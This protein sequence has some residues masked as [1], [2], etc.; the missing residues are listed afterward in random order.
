MTCFPQHCWHQPCCCRLCVC[1]EV[2]SE[3]PYSWRR[4]R[5]RHV[6]L[7][8]GTQLPPHT[9]PLART[10]AQ[11]VRSPTGSPETALRDAVP[12]CSPSTA[13][14]VC[15]CAPPLPAVSRRK[16]LALAFK[17]EGEQ[18]LSSPGSSPSVGCESPGVVPS[19]AHRG[20]MAREGEEA[21]PAVP[22]TASLAQRILKRLGVKPSAC[23]GS[24]TF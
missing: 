20:L 7:A 3:M 9:R 24:G 16:L 8:E 22:V 5:R 4:R 14:A 21:A 11:R 6:N 18:P 13:A 15:S 19:L 12:F 2:P 1:A 17:R 23:A 10:Q